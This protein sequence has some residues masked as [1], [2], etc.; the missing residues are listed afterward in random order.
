LHSQSSDKKPSQAVAVIIP[1]YYKESVDYLQESIDSMVQQETEADVRI[2]LGIDGPSNP[3][4]DQFLAQNRK[5]L[6]K[7]IHNDQPNGVSV[8]LN[9]LID[10]LEDEQFIFRHDA[11][12]VALP[13]R[14]QAQLDFLK[15]HPEV[16]VCG[17]SII[18]SDFKE[19]GYRQVINYPL[20]HDEIVRTFHRRSPVAHPACCF[21][22]EVF[23]KGYRYPVEALYNEDLGLWLI[24]ITN[25][26]RFSNMLEPLIEFRIEPDFY[27]KRGYPK[28]VI[29]FH[30][31]WESLDKLGKSNMSKIF[32]IL[33]FMFRVTPN[34]V[35]K[36][37]Y[38]SGFRRLL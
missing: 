22:V 18:E 4:I 20:T 25:G 6:Y 31:F 12:D 33:R 17:G 15:V 23:K 28:A 29:E 26:I 37:G 36:I 24:L 30:L 11:D 38:R 27:R 10:A 16:D 7:V 5:K 14:V 35:K 9:K 8:I 19:G 1:F 3:Q 13:G 34:W 2:Y 21:R 32:P